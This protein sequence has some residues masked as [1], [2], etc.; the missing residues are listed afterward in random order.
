[1]PVAAAL[2]STRL[3]AASLLEAF[4]LGGE[5]T[6]LRGRSIWDDLGN[7]SCDT[8]TFPCIFGEAKQ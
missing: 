1:M 4:W 7:F 8:S 2:P 6:D 3:M 5:T